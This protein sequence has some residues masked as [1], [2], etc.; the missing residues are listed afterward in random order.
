M[1]EPLNRDSVSLNALSGN[2]IVPGE[3]VSVRLSNLP[4][5]GS[6]TNTIWLVLT[7]AVFGAGFVLVFILRRRKL[8]AT[9]PLADRE[10]T[11]REALTELAQLDDDFADGKI[12]K[13]A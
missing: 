13:E 5:T 6:S 2:N 8:V 3:Q 7:L 1:C 9:A 12:E 11:Y 4:V 10:K